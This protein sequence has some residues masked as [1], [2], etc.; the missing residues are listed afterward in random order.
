MKKVI[1]GIY[2]NTKYYSIRKDGN[3]LTERKAKRLIDICA[4]T[5]TTKE[6][7]NNFY[8]L[9]I[10]DFGKRDKRKIVELLDVKNF[11]VKDK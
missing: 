5:K 1:N 11:I 6:D 9:F 7:R 10:T 8:G 2:V 3:K 4:L